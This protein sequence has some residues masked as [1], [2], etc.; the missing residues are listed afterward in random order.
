MDW[1]VALVA[2]EATALEV[3]ER[4]AVVEGQAGRLVAMV[5]P[6]LNEDQQRYMKRS[7]VNLPRAQVAGERDHR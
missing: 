5:T 6:A 1:I 4:P 2:T 3:E 7:E